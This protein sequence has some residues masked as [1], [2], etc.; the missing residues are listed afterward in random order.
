VALMTMKAGL[1]IGSWAPINRGFRDEVALRIGELYRES[2][3]WEFWL[4]GRHF[5]DPP[6]HI[7]GDAVPGGFWLGRVVFQRFDATARKA[8][9]PAA[10]RA[11][12]SSFSEAAYLMPRLPHFGR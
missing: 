2:A 9:V 1:V 10:E 6:A 5:D 7:I 4:I 12:F 11:R 3:G 8:V